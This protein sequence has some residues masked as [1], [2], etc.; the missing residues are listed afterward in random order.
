MPYKT[1]INDAYRELDI[2]SDSPI[3]TTHGKIIELMLLT[4]TMN[5]AMPLDLIKLDRI[6]A[7]DDYDYEFT[8]KDGRRWRQKIRVDLPA[9][10]SMSFGPT[11]F[12][13]LSEFVPHRPV[14]DVLVALIQTF[15]VRK[16]T[17]KWA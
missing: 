8:L 6:G 9:E 1:T 2:D 5:A 12:F 13:T 11:G 15:G 14:R 7:T 17:L 4:V 10:P 3:E 16:L